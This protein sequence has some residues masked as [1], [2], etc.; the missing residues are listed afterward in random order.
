MKLI[1]S[2]MSDRSDNLPMRLIVIFVSLMLLTPHDWMIP[3]QAKAVTHESRLSN[4]CE[5]IMTT[6]DDKFIELEMDQVNGESGSSGLISMEEGT[7]QNRP[8]FIVHTP[9]VTYYYDRAGGG[10][11]RILDRNG[12]D[13]ID[14]KM[15]PWGEYPASA[16]SAFRGLPNF[17]HGSTHA[18][19]GHPGH[20][21]C[22]SVQTDTTTIVTTSKSGIWE[23]EWSFFDKYARVKLLKIDAQH[24]YW[25]L[26]EGIPGGRYD[27]GHQYFGSD[28]DTIPRSGE[29]DYYLGSK[30]FD[31]FHW[32][33]FGHQ[34]VDRVMFL[35]QLDPD[36]KID[37]FSYLG[38]SK[39]GI[40]S[41][42]GMVVFGFGRADGAKPLLDR[43]NEFIIGFWE[44]QISDVSGHRRIG[45]FLNQLK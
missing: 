27:P 43:R 26:Y 1:H 12:I 21:Q 25:F 44:D 22:V 37:T 19:A 17:V 7:Y 31:H 24:P 16:A 2:H 5:D 36:D 10:F 6:S 20:D 8:H 42:D 45:N 30:L 13:W 9:N 38:N 28:Q 40:Q 41:D 11:S 29:W 15:Q 23:W 14:F 32:V 3:P 35:K 18:G 39:K 4:L 33:Y 34:D